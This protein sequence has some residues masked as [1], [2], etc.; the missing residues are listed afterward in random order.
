MSR[1]KLRPPRHFLREL[2]RRP[3]VYRRVPEEYRA[4][5]AIWMLRMLV[6]ANTYPDDLLQEEW[7]LRIVG[8]EVP[9]DQDQKVSKMMRLFKKRLAELECLSLH[10]EGLLYTNIDRLAELV[11]LTPVEKELLAFI[12]LLQTQ[13][14]LRE[15]ADPFDGLTSPTAKEILSEI[16]GLDQTEVHRALNETGTLCSA[17]IVR[18]DR[19]ETDLAGMLDLL[20]G[21]DSAL[22]GEPA[23]DRTMFE[24]YFT[25][26]SPSS[27]ALTDFPHLRED[28]S[29]MQNILNK[30]IM[31]GLKGVNVLIYGE[32]GTGKTQ[33]ARVLAATLGAQLF[34]VSHENEGSDLD[35]KHQRFRAYLLAE[36]I[37]A[38]KQDSIILFD[39]IEDV[40]PDA[41]LEFFG[42]ERQSG[43]YKAWTNK[44][45]ESNPRPALWLCNEIH[46]I[47]PAF[48]RR[49]TYA[50]HV[51][52]PTRSVRRGILVKHLGN[53][54]V[55]QAWIEKMAAN[56]QLTPAMMEQVCKVASLAGETDST[57]VERLMERALQ[58]SLE[59]MGLPRELKNPH[60]FSITR[61]SLNF[62]NPSQDLAELTQGL[63]KKPVGRLCFYGPPGSGKTSYA[64]Y[65]A[66]QVDKPLLKK[67]A[68]DI[69][70]MWVG[71]T[72]KNIAEMF[73][74][75]QAENALLLLD[76]ADSFLQDRTGAHRS[77]EFTQV[78]ELLTQMEAFE[79]L[80]LCSTNLILSLDQAVLRRF[81]LKISFGYLRPEQSW[82]MFLQTL[83]GMGYRIEDTQLVAVLQQRLHQLSTLTPGDFATVTR[84]AHVLGKPF[85]GEQ[86]LTALEA[87]CTAKERG[88]KQVQGFTR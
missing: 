13:A 44:V 84:Q 69:L 39:E 40:F 7:F 5:L 71:G 45:L 80:F 57:A 67:L 76:E 47:D 59:V 83:D 17:G 36:S 56:Q 3:R 81:D 11:V 24:P 22:L 33:L 73:R 85:D 49:F 66:E 1:G 41:V 6:R 15:C 79:G 43:R 86:L 26:S 25:L 52:T 74:E 55:S 29:L 54:P 88:R 4:P 62:L 64:H 12:V 20:D 51:R 42:R 78:N 87:E 23:N 82:A 30:A 35:E 28:F 16:L 14:V 38:R 61:Y 46:Q 65:L 2:R 63:K 72:E 32:T 53:L 70:S 19:T 9:T 77:W 27:L 18:M 10:R 60:H 37:L 50:L 48:R 8:L 34:E 31:Q 75:A 58:N 68:S 21:L